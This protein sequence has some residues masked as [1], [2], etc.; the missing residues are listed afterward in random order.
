MKTN[1][2][3]YIILRKLHKKTQEILLMILVLLKL[4]KL[5]I[6]ILKQF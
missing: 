2:N 1:T 3:K 4:I 6:E 5:L